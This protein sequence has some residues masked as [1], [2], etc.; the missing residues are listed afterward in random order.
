MSHSS[1]SKRSPTIRDVAAK[2]NAGRTSISRYFN[3]EAHLLSDK[4]KARIEAAIQEL[5]Y[6]PNQMA[7]SLKHG[8][9][10]LI[11]LII[12]DISNPFSVEVLK[13][14]ESESMKHGFM[15]VVCNANNSIKLECE[16]IHL[17]KGYRV[18]GLIINSAG[19]NDDFLQALKATTLPFVLLDRKIPNIPCD[20]VGLDNIQ[21]AQMAFKHLVDQGFEALCFIT[22]PIQYNSARQERLNSF[23]SELQLSPHIKGEI[24]EI[25]LPNDS[26]LIS[27]IATFC[28]NHRGMRKAIIAANGVLSLKI[29]YALKHLGLAWGADIGFL[30]FDNLEWAELAGKGI[31]SISQPTADMGKMAVSILL[32]KLADPKHQEQEHLFQ[33][34]LVVRGS[35]TL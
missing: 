32:D 3:G 20:M 33:G 9:S 10:Q 6:R 14:V 8:S 35:T 34:E 23:Q 25:E 5:N 24:H 28:S 19:V 11:G 17:L 12:A 2:A 29:A 4:L 1:K 21:S 18:D 30:S 31:T 15:T 26:L 22:E 27:T 7:R 13:G 16:F